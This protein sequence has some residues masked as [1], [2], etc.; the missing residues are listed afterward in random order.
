MRWKTTLTLL[1]AT[2]AL[3][4]Y[5]SLYELRQ[6]G[7]EEREQLASQ[8]ANILPDEITGLELRTRTGTTSLRQINGAWRVTQPIDARADDAAV[9]RILNHFAPLEAD[10]T[11]RPAKGKPLNLAEFGLAPPVTSIAVTT[12]KGT[13]RLDI[14]ES[15]AVG[16]GRYATR[17]G[18]PEVYIIPAAVFDDV[19]KPPSDLRSHDVFDFKSWDADRLSVMSLINSFTLTKEK[20]RWLISTPVF[21]AADQ[22]AA[23]RLLDTVAK[24]PIERV[25]ADD[26]K[27]EDL[28]QWGFDM[29]TAHLVV[30]VANRPMPVDLYIGKATSDQPDQLYAKR[31]DERAIYAVSK[32]RVDALLVDPSTLRSRACFV[33]LE[34]KVARVHHE[35]QGARWSLENHDGQ[36]VNVS[37][38]KPVDA[39][40]VADLLGKLRDLRLTRFMQDGGQNL[41]RYGLDPAESVIAVQLSQSDETQQLLIGAESGDGKNRYGFLPSRKIVVELPGSILELLGMKIETLSTP[42]PASPPPAVASQGSEDEH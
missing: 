34:P 19:N 4:A 21:D 16:E 11:L 32:A 12:P 2:V 22:Q 36:W 15:T 9:R 24:L 42:M 5:V 10:R 39:A 6:P 33:F 41:A 13:T 40:R 28:P 3:G 38:G 37:T 18:Q 23:D 20:E 1:I 14:G 27:V 25:I 8:V 29:P 17:P 30:L 7:P 35:W 26:P 31:V